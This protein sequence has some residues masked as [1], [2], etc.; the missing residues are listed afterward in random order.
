[1]RRLA[2]KLGIEV[3]PEG[4]HGVAYPGTEVMEVR[5]AYLAPR[6][7]F[8][9]LRLPHGL[10]R[11]WEQPQL[12]ES[13]PGDNVGL[14]GLA[15]EPR[16]PWAPPGIGTPLGRDLEWSQR[17]ADLVVLHCNYA[18]PEVVLDALGIAAI[19]MAD[20]MVSDTGPL[21]RQLEACLGAVAQQVLHH[22]PL[23]A[24]IAVSTLCSATVV[25]YAK[26]AF[27]SRDRKEMH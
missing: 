11:T 6:G 1:M 9:L 10:C 7:P 24:L 15:L 14:H 3:L 4:V 13:G 27:R 19:T 17:I 25:K 2:A 12:V 26:A 21:E 22:D 18:P 8:W 20:A 23:H 16:N 5:G